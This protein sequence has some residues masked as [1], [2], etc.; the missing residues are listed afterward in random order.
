[1]FSGRKRKIR[2][3]TRPFKNVRSEVGGDVKPAVRREQPEEGESDDDR[4]SGEFFSG[5]EFD[6]DDIMLTKDR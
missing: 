6:D 2:I 3:K 5:E 1:M 4:G